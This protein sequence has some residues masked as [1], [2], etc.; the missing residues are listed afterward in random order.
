M[1]KIPCENCPDEKGS[2]CCGII[3]FSLKFVEEHKAQFQENGDLKEYGNEV[4]VLTPDLLCIFFDRVNHRCAIYD[5]R[6]SVCVEY[7][8]TDR[9]P[10]PFYRKS[11]NRRTKASEKITLRQINKQV[12]DTYKKLG[13]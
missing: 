5:E 9:L 6:P 10:C 1:G 11:G 7:G 3:P 13:R 4:V 12:D 8:T 2:A